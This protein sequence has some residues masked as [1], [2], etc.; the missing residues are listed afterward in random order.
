MAGALGT[1]L[2]VIFI[3]VQQKAKLGKL[4]AAESCRTR[5][6]KLKPCLWG[7]RTKRR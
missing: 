4:Q 1:D 2:V 3:K 6:G 7:E 5:Q